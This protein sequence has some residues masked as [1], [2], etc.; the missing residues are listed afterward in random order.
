MS[1]ENHITCWKDTV[2]NL[3]L[4]DALEFLYRQKYEDY[5]GELQIRFDKHIINSKKNMLNEKFSIS[6]VC[7]NKWILM[8]PNFAEQKHVNEIRDLIKKTNMSGINYDRLSWMTINDI[9]SH[10]ND[11]KFNGNSK[12][13]IM[14]WYLENEMYKK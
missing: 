1:K 10:F 2:T 5:E 8:I 14:K 4:R 12:Y 11:F 13:K 7:E 9:W 3:S 6:E